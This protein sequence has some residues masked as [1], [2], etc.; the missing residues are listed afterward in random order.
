MIL[1]DPWSSLP[2]VHLSSRRRMKVIKRAVSFFISLDF[3]PIV[4]R[5]GGNHFASRAQIGRIGRGFANVN[6]IL[7]FGT[8]SKM[9]PKFYIIYLTSEY[10]RKESLAFSMDK[11]DFILRLLIIFLT[12]YVTSYMRNY[13]FTCKASVSIAELLIVRTNYT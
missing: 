12:I 2:P 6:F 1:H 9:V 3:A 10:A 4:F 8:R 11:I 5:G 13:Q 7:A